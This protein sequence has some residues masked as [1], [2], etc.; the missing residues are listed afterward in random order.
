MLHKPRGYVCSRKREGDSKIIYDLLPSS[1]MRR[2]PLVV[3]AGRLDKWASGLLVLSQ[4]GDIIQRLTSPKRKTTLGKQYDV[5]LEKPISGK[6]AEIFASGELMLRSE[7]E[8]CL[9]ALF[10]VIDKEERLVRYV[11]CIK[12]L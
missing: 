4:S 8:P 6:E 5:Q 10:E 11:M 2:K 7:T 12:T 9:P 1:F 3:S